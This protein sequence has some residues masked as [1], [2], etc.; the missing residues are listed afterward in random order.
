MTRT[1]KYMTAESKDQKN[2]QVE[3]K[4]SFF[5]ELKEGWK[6][7]MEYE[8]KHPEWFPYAQLNYCF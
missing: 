5:E 1:K 4:K 7:A 3:E 2:T 8:S 6:I